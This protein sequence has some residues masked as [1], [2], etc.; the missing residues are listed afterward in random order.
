VAAAARV[1]LGSLSQWSGSSGSAAVRSAA[2]WIREFS[3]LWKLNFCIGQRQWVRNMK[4][5]GI[6]S[7]SDKA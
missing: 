7:M 3:I 5:V 1:L 2:I 6:R 4:Y